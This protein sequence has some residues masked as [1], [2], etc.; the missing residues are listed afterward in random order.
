MTA[1]GPYSV[2]PAC[3][4]LKTEVVSF[5]DGTEIERCQDCGATVDSKQKPAVTVEA[6]RGEMLDAMLRAG[7]LNDE[8]TESQASICARVAVR[9]LGQGGKEVAD[10]K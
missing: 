1:Q 9:L 8:E 10:G 3:A 6:L 4:H 7:C 2:K 5:R